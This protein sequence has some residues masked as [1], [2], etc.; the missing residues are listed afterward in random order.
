MTKVQLHWEI[1]PTTPIP[2]LLAWKPGSDLYEMWKGLIVLC[3]NFVV[4]IPAGL[5][6]S[7]TG[8]QLPLK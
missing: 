6:S 5:D 8:C 2:G 1:R 4:T 7:V 3:Q